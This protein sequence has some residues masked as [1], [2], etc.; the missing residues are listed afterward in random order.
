MS[1]YGRGDGNGGRDNDSRRGFRQQNQEHRS[2]HHDR[3][4]RGG[5]SGRSGG[6]GGRGNDGK[7]C[8]PRRRI[9]LC[10]RRRVR[11]G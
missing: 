8:V 11:F 5:G 9:V 10:K 7:E 6:R 1:Y 4:N 3:D 2:F